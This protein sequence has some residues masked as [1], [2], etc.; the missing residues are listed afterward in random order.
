MFIQFLWNI[1]HNAFIIAAPLC[2]K[3]IIAYIECKDC[4]PPTSSNY[5]WVVALLATTVADSVCRQ[6]CIHV[7]RRLAL[8]S[9]S[10]CNTEVFKKSL[11]RKDIASSAELK[12]GEEEKKKDSSANVSSMFLPLQRASLYLRSF[13]SQ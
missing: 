8:K 5:L 11:L 10:V 3:N 6:A 1:P 7:G 13:F 4:G 12:E 9:T 2:S